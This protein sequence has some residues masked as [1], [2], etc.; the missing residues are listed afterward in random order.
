MDSSWGYTGFPAE[1]TNFQNQE[2][3]A[4]PSSVVPPGYPVDA[5]RGPDDAAMPDLIDSSGHTSLKSTP[6][7]ELFYACGYHDW[8]NHNQRNEF[9]EK[10]KGAVSKLFDGSKTWHKHLESERRECVR[11]F[12]SSLIV[13]Y[14][15]LG[16][17][18]F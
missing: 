12:L 16:R 18:Q 7:K 11:R 14:V 9:N 4:G 10:K 1:Y 13:K 6:M 17:K 3:I 15:S 8:E 5:G 2:F